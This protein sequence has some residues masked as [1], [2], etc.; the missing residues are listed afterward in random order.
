MGCE[1]THES[2]I[3]NESSALA[4]QYAASPV[5]PATRLRFVALP[6]SA[7]YPGRQPATRSRSVNRSSESAPR[8][9]RHAVRCGA[10]VEVVRSSAT[11]AS[12]SSECIW[13][14]RVLLMRWRRLGTRRRTYGARF[15]FGGGGDACAG[16]PCF[17]KRDP[18]GQQVVEEFLFKCCGKTLANAGCPRGRRGVLVGAGSRGL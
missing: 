4:R 9:S 17:L 11:S 5:S 8:A 15:A 16:L 10:S 7:V 6:S 12:D 18:H 1:L 3:V 2:T 14:K 13:G